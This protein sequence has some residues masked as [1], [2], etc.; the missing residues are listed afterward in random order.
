[1]SRPMHVCYQCAVCG[2][3]AFD[4]DGPGVVMENGDWC[5]TACAS[6]YDE[7]YDEAERALMEEYE[8]ELETDE[9]ESDWPD[10]VSDFSE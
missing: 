1:M 5:H 6:F 10:P 8:D 2:A 7:M 4:S 3:F 9:D